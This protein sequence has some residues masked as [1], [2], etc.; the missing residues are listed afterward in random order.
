LTGRLLLMRATQPVVGRWPRMFYPVAGPV[1]WLLLRLRR[2]LRARSVAN[3][4]PFVA[5]DR[6]EAER[7]AAH[8]MKNT[9]CYYIDLCSMPYRKMERFE[10]EHMEVV[11]GERL[12]ALREPGPVIAVSAHTGNA[13]LS[14]QALTYR[15]RPFIA[16]VEPQ[17]P[18]E[19]S[20][21]VL[22]IRSASGGAFY[23]ADF[24]GLRECVKTLRRGGVAGFMGDRD[25]QGNG[26][27][28]RLAE[29]C[30][31]LPRGPWQ[32]ARTENAL[33][34]PVFTS[35]IRD[36]GFRVFVEEPFRVLHS[37]DEE[38]DVRVAVERYARLLEAHLRRDPAQWAFTE[39]YWRA[40]DCG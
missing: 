27:C 33:V 6:E 38:T 28:T 22:K 10:T 31:R 16:L 9:V 23:E 3:M 1:S 35:R 20:R 30:V 15:G 13:E 11:G 17:A 39:D 40:H 25:I 32:M 36:D 4:L 12:E 7:L 34:F 26:L 29:R 18:P 37:E 21:Y 14:I 5:G 2:D 24:A 8:S 19:W